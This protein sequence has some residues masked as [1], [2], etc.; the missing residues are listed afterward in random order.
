M[1]IPK[2]HSETLFDVRV[3]RGYRLLQE[4]HTAKPRL[5]EILT[6]CAQTGASLPYIIDGKQPMFENPIQ[7]LNNKQI[8]ISSAAREK[9]KHI[10]LTYESNEFVNND[11]FLQMSPISLELLRRALGFASHVALDEKTK[12]KKINNEFFSLIDSLIDDVHTI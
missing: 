4:S 8:T 11:V 5:G 6:F 3:N 2:K 10:A 9:L 7:A 12:R 1:G